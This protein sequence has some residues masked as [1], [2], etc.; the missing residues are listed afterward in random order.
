VVVLSAAALALTAAGRPA[1]L[2]DT[3]AGLWEFSGPGT[4]KPDRVCVADVSAMAQL[5]HRRSRCT[6]VVIR[7]LPGMAEIHYT[8]TGGGFGRSTVRPI[9]P[10]SVK[11]E[12]Q[13]IADG[14]PFNY[15]LQGRRVGECPR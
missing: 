3:Q 5:Q 1:A 8:C 12:T 15:T 2:T 11:I 13:G 4:A 10:R 7:D 14:A 9:T 6:R